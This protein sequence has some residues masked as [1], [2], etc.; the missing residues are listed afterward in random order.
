[1][2]DSTIKL[3]AEKYKKKFDMNL[4]SFYEFLTTKVSLDSYQTNTIMEYLRE[5]N[6]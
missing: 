2:S 4:P 3:V 1:M 5:K 6:E